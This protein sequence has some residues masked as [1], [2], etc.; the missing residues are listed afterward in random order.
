MASLFVD[1]A[2]R[3]RGHGKLIGTKFSWDGV[4]FLGGNR[5]VSA[6][7]TCILTCARLW[8]RAIKERELTMVYADK[9]CE[10]HDE[11]FMTWPLLKR[12]D[13]QGN[14]TWTNSSSLLKDLQELGMG[15]VLM[16]NDELL[17]IKLALPSK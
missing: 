7:A 16:T 11:V 5:D 6:S 15:Q 4:L 10:N 3:V 9:K 1:G 8:E 12:A 17:E 13:L 14:A 2:M